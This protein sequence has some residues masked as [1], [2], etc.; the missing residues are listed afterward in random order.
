[1]PARRRLVADISA[2]RS[3]FARSVLVEAWRALLPDTF[4]TAVPLSLRDRLR[5]GRAERLTL[6]DDTEPTT[7]D[8][9]VAAGALEVLWIDHAA[10]TAAAPAPARGVVVTVT[11]ALPLGRDSDG[12]AA[13]VTAVAGERDAPVITVVQLDPRDADSSRALVRAIRRMSTIPVEFAVHDISTDVTAARL[14]DAQLVLTA[15]RTAEHVARSAGV[16]TVRLGRHDDLTELFVALHAPLDSVDLGLV[17]A[18]RATAFAL[19]AWQ[20][21][22]IGTEELRAAVRSPHVGGERVAV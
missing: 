8:G 17:R 6:T 14:V 7:D 1:M 5:L 11:A 21:H 3:S 2:D 19:D 20:R 16:P 9:R 10:Q 15:D 4:D 12:L 18:A 13:A 22:R